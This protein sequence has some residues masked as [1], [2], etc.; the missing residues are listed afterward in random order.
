MRVEYGALALGEGIDCADNLVAAG[1]VLVPA[2]KGGHEGKVLQRRIIAEGRDTGLD[3]FM[4]LAAS[5]FGGVGGSASRPTG[6]LAWLCHL[7]ILKN[8][9]AIHVARF[10]QR[11]ECPVDALC[12]VSER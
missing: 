5:G 9:D 11:L 2:A 12:E 6:F 8:V 3:P 4:G 10:A 7:V 1:Q